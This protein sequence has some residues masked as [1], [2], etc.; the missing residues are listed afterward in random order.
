MVP[1]YAELHTCQVCPMHG[2]EL[3]SLV[4]AGASR[5][6]QALSLVALPAP[7]TQ[8]TARMHSCQHLTATVVQAA[9]R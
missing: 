9:E 8:D 2:A 4:A 6:A 5:L 7:S 3:Q 1:L